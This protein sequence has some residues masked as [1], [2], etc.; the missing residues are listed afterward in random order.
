[1]VVAEL[2]GHWAKEQ[3]AVE[4]QALDGAAEQQ[5]T[6]IENFM[7]CEMT[8]YEV[9]ANLRGL[10]VTLQTTAEQLTKEQIAGTDQ[11]TKEQIADAEELKA[12][13]EH[14]LRVGQLMMEYL[15]ERRALQT[16]FYSRMAQIN[17]MV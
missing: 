9:V 6:D 2:L 5:A 17:M 8:K 15:H 4:L 14:A 13:T 12:A 3:I 16:A 1:M 7:L 10:S 11:L